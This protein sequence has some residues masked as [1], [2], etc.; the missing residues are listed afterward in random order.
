MCASSGDGKGLGA[1]VEMV[2]LECGKTS[3]VVAELTV[4]ACLGN[5]G[6]LYTS[7]TAYNRLDPALPTSVVAARLSNVLD[8]SMPWTDDHG[9]RKILRSSSLHA[10]PRWGSLGAMSS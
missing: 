9:L 2:K 3:R 4:S 1:R 8:R 5:Q 7:A 6:L 10:V